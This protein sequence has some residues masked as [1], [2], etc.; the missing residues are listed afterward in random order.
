MMV[1]TLQRG[2]PARGA[3]ASRQQHAGVFLCWKRC[4]GNT[5]RLDAAHIVLDRSLRVPQIDC[6]LQVQPELR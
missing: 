5:Q 6:A 4:S 1:P 2:N 3:P